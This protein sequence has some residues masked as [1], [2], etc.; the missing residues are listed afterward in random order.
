[1]IISAHKFNK[2]NK[3]N[4]R[5]VI[6]S[7]TMV[8][9]TVL[10]TTLAASA[11]SQQSKAHLPTNSTVVALG[12]SL[13]FGYGATATNAY[14][15]VLANMTSW[16]VI[17]AGVNGNTSA[18]VLA[19]V[20]QVV[21]QNPDLVL[22]G[23][24]GN[25]VLRKIDSATTIANITA[26]IDQLQANRILVVLIAEPHFSVSALF[27]RASDNPI[28]K[29]IADSEEIPLYSKGWSTVL[30]DDSL[31]S[32]QIHANAAGY[33]QFAEGLYAYLQDEGWAR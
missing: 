2:T 22:L 10:G 20:D 14:P 6:L 16:Q 32:D 19:R 9:S 3:F 17:N 11:C 28:Y 15:T 13:T 27:G 33:R 8:L 25:D 29:N 24:G 1:M 4:P 7:L 30:S 31:K 12:D 23:V 21:A 26:T 5:S 18:D